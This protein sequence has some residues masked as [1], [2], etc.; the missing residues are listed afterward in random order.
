MILCYILPYTGSIIYLLSSSLRIYVSSIPSIYIAIQS[1]P[2]SISGAAL[3]P[4][5]VKSTPPYQRRLPPQPATPP[6][7][8]IIALAL[9][10]SCSLPRFCSSL[11]AAS[12][13]FLPPPCPSWPGKRKSPSRSL[14]L[15]TK[16][17][18]NSSLT[19]YTPRSRL[20]A[21]PEKT[22]F[23]H[24]AASH[25][26][27][28]PLLQTPWTSGPSSTPTRPWARPG[29]RSCTSNNNHHHHH[30][31]SITSSSILLQPCS[32]AEI[33]GTWLSPF[34]ARLY[35]RTNRS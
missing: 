14:E 35:T 24:V 3:R 13:H 34:H 11:P 25:L 27:P 7:G 21:P 18:P 15:P 23:D 16:K 9:V 30:H 2:I 8:R 17:P 32:S 31:H 5:A 12:Y 33:N 29:V 1:M 19:N 26:I 10:F 20:R 4:A 22:P 6:S 28:R